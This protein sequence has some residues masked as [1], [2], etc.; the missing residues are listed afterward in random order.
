MACH[1]DR[2]EECTRYERSGETSSAVILK[3]VR[4][5]HS[6]EYRVGRDDIRVGLISGFVLD[7]VWDDN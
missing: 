5:L 2:S 1:F 3:G 7:F 6:S 4:S